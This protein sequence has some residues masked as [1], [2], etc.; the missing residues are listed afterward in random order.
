MTSMLTIDAPQPL[1]RDATSLGYLVIG[2]TAVV[3]L[4][5][6]PLRRLTFDEAYYACGA[7]HGTPWPI[8]QH[9]PLL[10][11]LLRAASH[12]PAIPVELRVRI[13]SIA[14]SALTSLGVAHLAASIA[15]PAVRARSFFLGAT[16]A[17]WGLLPMCGAVQAIP[18]MPLLASLAWLLFAAH[19]YCEGR[20]R[21][22]LAAAGLVVLTALALLSKGSAVPCVFAIFAALAWR[23]KLGAAAAVALGT[24]VAAPSFLKAFF[25]QS[26]HAVGQGPFVSAPRVGVFAALALG[27]LAMFV[28]FGPAAIVSGVRARDALARIPGG[29]GTAALITAACAISAVA[30]GRLP[31]VHWF[32]PA[33]IPLYA[34]AAAALAGSALVARRVLVSH[35]VPT[36]AAVVAWCMPIRGLEKSDFFA[37]APHVAF[38]PIDGDLPWIARAKTVRTIPPYGEESWRCLY[39]GQCEEIERKF[40]SVR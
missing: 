35:V 4:C 12:I 40:G 11:A 15:A 29:A 22:A 25:A 27:G 18:E 17:S 24:L 36:V 3:H 16:I 7:T 26:G 10:G 19:A 30:S 6:A 23:R 32:A 39:A 34:A 20:V 38:S 2:A 37:E 33:S 9:P 31:E 1:V 28:A 13:V 5:I 21:P 8:P 14:L